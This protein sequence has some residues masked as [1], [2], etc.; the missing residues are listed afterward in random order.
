M[1]EDL[2]IDHV[3]LESPSIL[4]KKFFFC[5]AIGGGAGPPAPLVYAS[6]PGTRCTIDS[7][8]LDTRHRYKHQA[9]GALARA[10]R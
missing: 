3:K 10:Q 1:S 4:T 5:P 7:A 6:T 9:I 8:N 2:R